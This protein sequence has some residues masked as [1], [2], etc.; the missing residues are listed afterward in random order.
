MSTFV[1]GMG[2]LSSTSPGFDMVFRASC[3]MPLFCTILWGFSEPGYCQID[4]FTLVSSIVHI[5]W[6]HFT[7]QIHS[8]IPTTPLDAVTD[9]IKCIT[10]YNGLSVARCIMTACACRVC[11][12]GIFYAFCKCQS[13]KEAFRRR[14]TLIHNNCDLTSLCTY[15]WNMIFIHC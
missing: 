8:R 10:A 13:A 14:R 12:P 15:K 2:A 4:P 5:V 9:E 11:A 6:L 1:W 7:S 3:H